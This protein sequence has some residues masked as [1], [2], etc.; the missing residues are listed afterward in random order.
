MK[1]SDYKIR[2]LRFLYNFKVKLPYTRY[3]ISLLYRFFKIIKCYVGIADI[4]YFNSMGKPMNW[5]NPSDLNQWI[6]W[7]SY[8]TDIS[9]WPLLADKYRV[10]EFLRKAG[11]DELVL[12]VLRKWD[13]PRDISFEE[14]PKAFVLKLN[15]GSGD[16]MIIKDKNHVDIKKIR[17]YFKKRIGKNISLVLGERHYSKIK[18]L[19]FAEPLLDADLQLSKS[20]SLIDY[21]FW[22]FNGQVENIYTLHNRT[23]K[24]AEVMVYDLNWEPHPELSIFDGHLPQA[25][26]LLKRPKNFEKMVKIA[27]ELSKGFPEIRVDLYEVEDK[28]YFGEFTF[29]SCGGQMNYFNNDYLLYMGALCKTAYNNLKENKQK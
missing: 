23:K 28:I 10:K 7:L 5:D 21:K 27:S 25:K 12:P 16:V 24:S 11:F 18:P 26:Q 19:I 29:T 8:N 9:Q 3:L 17:L 2:C 4:T 1:N 20:T 14:L 6:L 22:C 13:N 15:N